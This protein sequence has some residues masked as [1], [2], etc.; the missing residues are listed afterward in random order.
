MTMENGVGIQTKAMA[1]AQHMEDETQ[2]QLGNNLVQVQGTNP[3]AAT[4]QRTAN[5]DTPNPAMNPTLNL[6]KTDDEIIEGFVRR[7]SAIGL[8]WHVPK[9]SN[10]GVGDLIRDR[11]P[12]ETTRGR[13]LFNCPPLKEYFCTTTFKLDLT[14]GRVYKFL[15]P[16]EDI[17][18]PCQQEEFDLNLLAEKLENGQDSSEHRMEELERIPL[19]RKIAAPADVME[20]DEIKDKIHQYCKLWKLYAET[21][22]EL[23]RKSKLSREDAVTACKVYKLYNKST[24]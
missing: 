5:P 11:L 21:S 17:G 3:V 18:I 6:Y 10:T 13:I 9:F 12:I 7:H 20:L 2:R 8:D 15:T 16:P 24:R 4:G 23:K 1:E 19:I 22:V 14:T